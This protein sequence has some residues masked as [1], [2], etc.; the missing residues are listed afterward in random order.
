MNLDSSKANPVG[1][2]PTDMLK[3]TIDI[4]LPIITQITNVSVDNNCYP[5][6]L[7]LAEVNPVFK[8]KDDLDVSSVK[9]LRQN[10][11]PTSRLCPNNKF[12]NRL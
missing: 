9:G 7:K 4:H 11:V 2:I 5:D 1:D 6:N 10:Y 8:K 12:F 3:Q